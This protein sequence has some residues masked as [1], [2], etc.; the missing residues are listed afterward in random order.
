[1]LVNCVAYENGHK[2]AEMPI[3]QISDYLAKP[4]VFV[5]VALFEPSV[6]ELRVMQE[7]FQLH[8]LAILD[9]V[10][11]HQRPKTE[12]Y[13]DVIFS[14][15]QMVTV[16]ANKSLKVGELDIFTGP[17][18][19]LS[20][21]S[22]SDKVLLGVRARCEQDPHLLALGPAYVL[23]ALVDYVVDEYF[24]V[25]EELQA[26]LEEIEADIFMKSKGR[27]NIERL[28]YLK[29]KVSILKHASVPLRERFGH[30]NGGRI[31]VVLAQ[32]HLNEYFR[33]LND[34]LA[35]II[36][37]LE[38][39]EDSIAMTVQVNLSLVTIDEGEITKRLAAWA[40]IFGLATS[41]AGIW[42]MNF[43]KMPELQWQFGYPMALLTIFGG[44]SLLFWRFK[45]IKWL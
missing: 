11:G 2:I 29:Q 14:V 44:C 10:H 34:H 25:Q 18:F 39:I 38:S 21:R 6:D 43:E 12:E 42:G 7:E 32:A 3:D 20:I 41:F 27:Q 33:D 40:G 36:D 45:K 16:Q 30:F 1:M 35:R 26:E 37:Q 31:P 9:V 28:Y 17:N 13:G 24:E 15:V 19:I 4:G 23:Y 5:W 8:D 22:R